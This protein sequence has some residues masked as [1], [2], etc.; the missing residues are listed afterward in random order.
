MLP[1]QRNGDFMRASVCREMFVISCAV[2]RFSSLCGSCFEALDAKLV[3]CASEEDV[4]VRLL[5]FLH[6]R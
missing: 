3:R 4:D 5:V 1:A 2:S 6:A